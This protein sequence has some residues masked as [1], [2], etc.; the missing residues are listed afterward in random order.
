MFDVKKLKQ[1]SKKNKTQKIFIVSAGIA[2]LVASGEPGE[3][4][5]GGGSED[6]F[7]SGDVAGKTTSGNDTIT[8]GPAGGV[9]DAGAGDDTITGGGAV[10]TIYGGAGADIMDGGAGI[11][12]MVVVGIT[13]ANDYSLADLQNVAGTG[14][15][16]SAF[17]SLTDVNNHTISDVQNGESIDGGADGAILYIFGKVNFAGVTL[18]NIS[19]IYLDNEVIISDATL[20]GLKGQGLAE[21]IGDGTIKAESGL[22]D[23]DGVTVPA[24]VTIKDSDGNIILPE[25]SSN[26][27]VNVAENTTAVGTFAVTDAS[28]VG[29]VTYA[30]TG[31]DAALFNLDAATGAVT[32]KTAADFENPL[33]DGKDNVYDIIVTATDEHTKSTAQNVAISVT[34]VGEP[35]INIASEFYE[36]GR[37]FRVN[38]SIDNNQS[39]PS[40]INLTNGNFVITWSTDDTSIDTSGLAVL[41]QMFD[42]QGVKIGAEFKVNSQGANDQTLPVVA[43][44]NN[45]GFVIAWQTND[46]NQDGNS[47]A[48]K[49]QIYNA[50]GSPNG[51]ELLVNTEAS[52]IQGT[53]SIVGLENGGFVVT[54]DGSEVQAQIFTETG[55]KVGSELTLNSLTDGGQYNIKVTALKNGNFVASWETTDTTQDGSDNAIKAI[56]YDATGTIAVTEF[57]VNTL[58]TDDQ[59][60]PALAAL[61]N[62][63]F[64]VAWA[65]Q[66]DAED[67]DGYA[68][69]A[70]IINADGTTFAG[71][72]LVNEFVTNAQRYVAVTGLENG[73][74]VIVWETSDTTQDGDGRAI[75]AQVYSA[76]GSELGYEMMI[77]SE[78]DKHQKFPDISAASG[79][80]FVVTWETFDTEE[81]NT[82]LAVNAQIFAPDPYYLFSNDT[83]N[84]LNIE[85][86]L[87]VDQLGQSIDSVVITGIPTGMGFAVGSLV[88]DTL[89]L[90]QSEAK[91]LE[92]GALSSLEGLFE[93]NI[94]ANAS[95]GTSTTTS[96]KLHISKTI[97]SPANADDVGE[98]TVKAQFY[99][100]GRGTDTVNLV[101]T[102]D[103]YTYEISGD[104]LI[105]TEVSNPT[106]VDFYHS[107]EVFSTHDGA[108]NPTTMNDLLSDGY[109]T[110]ISVDDFNYWL[111]NVYDYDVTI[112]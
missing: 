17:L 29:T 55:E 42:K 93:L 31:V 103:K 50:D 74:F 95:D 63:G 79:G 105:V 57:L 41:A 2:S 3:G 4:G 45:G 89:T 36:T 80:G 85:T 1:I 104:N 40:I 12:N 13:G 27:A 76:S 81:L 18:A 73:G 97:A 110:G 28:A 25:F 51:S 67:G 78:F 101:E 21:L 86:L 48:I 7:S 33:D 46:F 44:I 61:E 92:F 39:D 6:G 83:V 19:K 32:L 77:N 60:E 5:D 88:G 30:L 22:L 71:E 75:K 47:D 53:P 37:E 38:T 91:T 112:A 96:I 109:I 72:F 90:T 35:D 52:G 68:V 26:A 99:D 16:V 102:H 111:I 87:H 64:V 69:K 82:G 11:D 9:V 14:I 98:N 20:Q 62:G 15:D 66:N 100:G 10:D 54:W 58:A 70:K 8:I 49:M 94:T 23:L 59:R 43:A 106:N 84:K 56:I 107:I 65:S 34:D 108:P 24:A